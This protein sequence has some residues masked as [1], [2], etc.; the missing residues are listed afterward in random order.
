MKV[1]NLNIF[2]RENFE[3]FILGLKAVE[4]VHQWGNASV[5]KVGGKIF[6]IYNIWNEKDEWQIAFK[7]SD[8]S[9]EILPNLKGI[10][11]AKYLARAKWVAISPNSELSQEDIKNYITEAH[12]IIAKK[13][14]K[15]KRKKLEL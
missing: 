7:C 8:M 1:K 10:K 3:Q 13:L 6:A 12:Q 14:S 4:I 9:F 2:I 15:A 5:G 11:K